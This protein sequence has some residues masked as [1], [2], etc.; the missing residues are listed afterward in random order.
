MREKAD[1]IVMRSLFSLLVVA[2][3][4]Y[5]RTHMVTEAVSDPSERRLYGLF[6]VAACGSAPQTTNN[7]D[8]EGDIDW[9]DNHCD[10]TTYDGV[11]HAT[12]ALQSKTR[13][14]PNSTALQQRFTTRVATAASSDD[15][16]KQGDTTMTSAVK[17]VRLRGGGGESRAQ[18]N[19]LVELSRDGNALFTRLVRKAFV[20]LYN[21]ERSSL[22][23][24]LDLNTLTDINLTVT[25]E[26]VSDDA[27]ASYECKISWGEDYEDDGY[28]DGY[29]YDEQ[30]YDCYEDTV[31]WEEN[32][33]H[34]GMILSWN[35]ERNYGVISVMDDYTIKPFNDSSSQLFCHGSNFVDGDDC[36]LTIGDDVQ[37]TIVWDYARDRWHA[38][39]VAALTTDADATCIAKMGLSG[40]ALSIW[41]EGIEF[42]RA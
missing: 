13:L 25:D 18:V 38:V 31:D 10:N 12:V 35:E 4:P 33:T 11:G 19:A 32:D 28:E 41:Y 6:E 27:W 9:H 16:D 36:A 40:A 22:S 17:L 29:E 20:M 21:E 23:D 14:L 5:T 26:E 3:R 42:F 37:F 34:V 2:A 7:T 24:I 15:T 8:D 1:R 39:A 30:Y